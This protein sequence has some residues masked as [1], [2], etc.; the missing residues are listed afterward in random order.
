MAKQLW[1]SPFLSATVASIQHQRHCPK[2]PIVAI[3]TTFPCHNFLWWKGKSEPPILCY[4]FLLVVDDSFVTMQLLSSS[5]KNTTSFLKS[6]LVLF[7]ITCSVILFLSFSVLWIWWVGC[8]AFGLNKAA[9]FL[10]IWKLECNKLLALVS[11]RLNTLSPF[12]FIF[13]LSMPSIE[14]C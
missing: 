8:D 12:L 14:G 7:R 1:R 6:M 13:L 4:Q 11:G 10:V 9:N 2:P 3:N 5:E